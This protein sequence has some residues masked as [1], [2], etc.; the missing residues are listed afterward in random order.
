[1]EIKGKVHLFFLN[2]QALLKENLLNWVFLLKIMIF[3]II[4]VR[5][6]M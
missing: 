3:K 4:L 5:L 6:T 1:M 2:S